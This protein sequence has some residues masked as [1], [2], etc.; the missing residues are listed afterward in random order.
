M[1]EEVL[2]PTTLEGQA[3]TDHINTLAGRV[4][5]GDIPTDDE[6][7]AAVLGM[8]TRRSGAIKSSP[9]AKKKRSAEA[10]QIPMDLNSLFGAAAPATKDE[11]KPKVKASV[12]LNDLFPSN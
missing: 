2:Q 8:R 5:R 1:T 3:L 6:V 7:R 11:P 10:A 12:D 9:T 4:M